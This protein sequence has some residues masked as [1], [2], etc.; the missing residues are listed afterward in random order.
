[1]MSST[2]K[3]V[4]HT[5]R[6]FSRY[7]EDGGELIKHKKSGNNFPARL[8]QILSDP[9]HAGAITWMPHGR[10]WRIVDKE[11]LVAEVIP[12]F[13]VCKK[14]ESFTRQLNGW[15]FKRLHQHGPDFGCYYHECFL[16]GIPEITCL[17]RRLPANRGKATPFA[18]GEPNFYRIEER[19]PL[20]PPP[21]VTA[22][23]VTRQGPDSNGA[24]SS[25]TLA[26]LSLARADLAAASTTL[27]GPALAGLPRRVSTRETP[28]TASAAAAAVSAAAPGAGGYCYLPSLRGALPPAPRTLLGG[29][30]P[31]DRGPA[32]PYFGDGSN[33]PP[34]AGP[35]LSQSYPLHQYNPQDYHASLLGPPRPAGA[36]DAALT[37]HA[38]Q[39]AA[40]HVAQHAAQHAVA[41]AR[42]DPGRPDQTPCAAARK[43]SAQSEP[44]SEPAA[45]SRPDQ[46]HSSKKSS[47]QQRTGADPFEPIPFS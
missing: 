14:Y 45:Q 46:K 25:L 15:G 40:Q 29:Y 20:P 37:I 21:R 39:H 28:A 47:E 6:D 30:A 16:R 36:L 23:P 4:D 24:T 34:F 22:A 10:A 35:A 38:A 43:V 2:L 18:E 5:Y 44:D 41:V 31:A 27:A 9:A 3:Y 19:Y 33:P 26:T 32:M 8:H 17:I 42:P 12:S 7:V 13:Y 1:M 11:K